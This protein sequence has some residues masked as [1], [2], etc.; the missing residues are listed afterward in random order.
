MFQA[1]QRPRV[2]WSMIA[3]GALVASVLAAGAGPAGAVT[4]RADHTTRLSA[5]VGDA[6]AD[7]MFVD[8][9]QGHV[10]RDAIN[11]IAYYGITQGTGD[12]TTYSPS[13]EVTRAQMAVFIARTAKAAG[14]DLGGT[15]NARF[16]DI[17]GTWQEAQDAINRL[18]SNGVIPSGG[19]FRPD[20]AITRAEMAT[21]LVGLLVEVA[22][23]VTKD[24]SGAILL[25]VSGSRSV[26]D[27]RFPDTDDP[28]IAAIYEL[29][30][31]TGA[32]AA[33]VQDRTKPP[34]DLNY[35]PDGTVDR[36][37]MAAF[38]TRALAHTSVRPAGVSAQFDGAD[39][40]VS[41]RDDKYQPVSRVTV[42]VFWTTADRADSAL[43]AD[44]TCSLTEV[45]RAD[46]SSF[47]CEIDDTDPVTGNDGD[48]TVEVIGLRRVPAGGATV[49]AWTGQDGDTVA[50][51]TDP[52]R[53]DVA[54]GDDVGFASETLV[55]TSFV[56]RKARI[57]GSVLYTMQLRDIVGKVSTGV[58][59]TDPARWSLS[60][61]TQGV[62]DPEVQ[63]LVS[64][65]AGT[66]TFTIGLA[67]RPANVATG[68][69][70]VTYTLTPEDNAPTP[71]VFANGQ[72]A[73]SGRVIFSDGASSIASGEA[74]VFI[75]TRAYVHVVGGFA[76]NSATVTVL[77]QYG[78]PFPGAKVQLASSGL[79]GTVTL[80]TG[81]LEVD[82][83]GSRRFAYQY[84]GP[85]GETETLSVSH[86]VDSISS[87]GVAATVYWATDAGPAGSGPVLAGDVGRKQVVA[88]DGSGPVLLAYDDNDRFNLGGAPATIAVFE[89]EL[90]EALRRDDPGLNLTWSNYRPGSDRRVTEYELS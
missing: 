13:Q 7:H 69:V 41:V 12:G 49:W 23:G 29:G 51:G 15:A 74:T 16:N 34:L 3:A 58:N 37:Q 30:V 6:S 71:I 90:A 4:D 55:T 19:A 64:D 39:V 66:V 59:G 83:R 76:S 20:D 45:T 79:T 86:G 1:V 78:D 56:A 85:G 65:G 38:I 84:R 53:F 54:E 36:G 2:G 14:L 32:S 35:E 80:D 28:E 9:S 63:T 31:T 43:M 17:D 48:A 26:A 22:P 11:C 73:A 77:D 24:S 10:F 52:Y 72:G 70:V 47:P 8:V 42:D 61:R 5:C 46:L 33:E 68:D 75:E 44:G 57:G 60:V 87:S 89:A 88:D 25:G 40:I 82:S 21:F 50:A 81:E 62:T 67:A 18:A 27:D